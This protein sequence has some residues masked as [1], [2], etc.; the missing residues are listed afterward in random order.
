VEDVPL[1]NEIAVAQVPLNM[2]SNRPNHYA[3]AVELW[4]PFVTNVISEADEAQ[5]VVAV[6]TNWQPEVFAADTDWTNNVIA[7]DDRYGFVFTNKIERMEQ[8]TDTEFVT[9]TLPPPYLSFPVTVT[10]A[11]TVPVEDDQQYTP[12]YGD[13]PSRL[14]PHDDAGSSGNGQPI[15]YLSQTNL[16][17]PLGISSYYTY[18]QEAEDETEVWIRKRIWAT[19]TVHLLARVRLGANW[20][21]EAAGYEPEDN[22]QPARTNLLVFTEP[23]GYE[24]DDPRRNGHR[25]DWRR[26]LPADR[27]QHAWDEQGAE[28][29]L[30][31][32]DGATNL[33][34][35]PWHQPYGQGLPLVHFN[36]PMRRAG[37][38]GYL[39]QPESYPDAYDRSWTITNLWQSICL[40][41]RETLATNN[42][43]YYFSAGSVLEFFTAHATNA[44]VRGL[45]NF[46]TTHT[47]VVGALMA[48]LRT[49]WGANSAPLSRDGI[50]WM[51]RIFF[52]AQ[53][54]LYG[55]ESVPIG[56]GDMCYGIGQTGEFLTPPDEHL[57]QPAVAGLHWEGSLGSDTKEDL[58]R[59]LAERISFRQHIFMIVMA[60]RTATP[61][62]R[63][64]ADQ[65]AVAVVIRDA[66]SGRWKL[67]S[68]E[69]LTR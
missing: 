24:V 60:A 11:G 2:S 1:I 62:E 42:A 13:D 27:G 31:S 36:G 20:V 63:I 44:P 47:N 57:L 39:Q 29:P 14:V 67:H 26:Y 17:L 10:R 53:E 66:Y 16:F 7:P 51:T 54:A 45:V 12:Q 65:R 41:A 9:A 37:E 40:A 4:Y 28:R 34:C 61:S 59:D 5:L 38:I 58:L 6:Y 21:D 19:N 15:F 56:V 23:C 3:P 22:G 32:L 8:G 68:W 64:T 48:D 25:E 18:V 43:G 30:C 50:D 52:S 33:I 69:R 35:N 49:G 55:Y 46:S